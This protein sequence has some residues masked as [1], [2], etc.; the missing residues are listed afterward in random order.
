MVWGSLQHL[1]CSCNKPTVPAGTWYLCHDPLHLSHILDNKGILPPYGPWDSQHG[2]QHCSIIHNH[3]VL[4]QHLGSVA[5]FS[6]LLIPELTSLV[7]P[8]KALSPFIAVHTQLVA[9]YTHMKLGHISYT[10][11]YSVLDKLVNYLV[12]FEK[13]LGSFQTSFTKPCHV[14]ST[15]GWLHRIAF[16]QSLQLLIITVFAV[17]FRTCLGVSHPDDTGLS[18]LTSCQTLPL[19][20]GHF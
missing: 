13:I 17:A 12:V 19:V 16:W 1:P 7:L 6:L 9:Q 14:S 11:I 18:I 4:P 3:S 2:W 10:T 20:V 5:S 15:L 8:S